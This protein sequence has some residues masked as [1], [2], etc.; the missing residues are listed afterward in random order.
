MFFPKRAFTG[1]K[2]PARPPHQLEYEGSISHMRTGD[3]SMRE[4]IPIK[5]ALP[6]TRRKLW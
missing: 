1:G 3:V 2:M 6:R 4:S 5:S